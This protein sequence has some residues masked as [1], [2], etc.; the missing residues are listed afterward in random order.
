MGF[1]VSMVPKCEGP[2][3]PGN[4][5][6]RLNLAVRP[7]MAYTG[8]RA[9]LTMTVTLH[10]KPEVEAGLL[11]QARASGMLLEDY[12]LSVVEGVTQP[13]RDPMSSAARGDRAE[14][15]RRMLEFGDRYRLSL[16]EPLT[17]ALLHEGH[18]Y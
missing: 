3:A 1:V 8:I 16:G 15:V 12:L 14:S 7:A 9:R 4:H 18:R 5:D 2:G 17:R 11:A 13:A 6:H 10:L